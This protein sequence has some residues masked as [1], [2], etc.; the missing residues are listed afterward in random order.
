MEY[1]VVSLP[2]CLIVFF[3]SLVQSAIGFGY[4]IIAIPLLTTFYLAPEIALPLSATTA[5]TQSLYGVIRFRKIIR[6]K[7]ILV[8]S[9]YCNTGMVAGVFS[10][11]ALTRFNSDLFG[12]V[13]GSILLIIITLRSFLKIQPRDSVPWYWGTTA[14]FTGGYICGLAGVGGPVIVLWILAHRW[15]NDRIRVTLWSVFLLMTTLQIFVYWL[16]FG[17]IAIRGVLSGL[18]LIPVVVAASIIGVV[19][20]GKLKVRSMSIFIT[21]LVLLISIYSIAKPFLRE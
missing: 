11:R 13:I 3:A 2:I 5:V 21:I 19:A 14:L 15:D 16:A 7:E 17:D 6:I 12:I 4:G 8:Y 10:L 20:G 1:L 9:L 18:I